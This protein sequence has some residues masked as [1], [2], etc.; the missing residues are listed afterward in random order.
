MSITGK[1]VGYDPGGNDKHGVAALIVDSGRPLQ[2]SFRTTRNAHAALHWFT[3]GGMPLAAGIDTLTALSTGDS[4]WRPADLW[5]RN[6][7][8]KVQN[9]VVNP[10][11]LQGS[12]ALNGL[13][14][15]LSLRAVCNSILIS[16]THPKVLCFCLSCH[17]YDYEKNQGAMN[18]HLAQW[19]G[20]PVNTANEHEWDAVISSFAV[21]KGMSGAWPMDLHQ[22][23]FR[24]DEAL[25]MPG[26]PS[27]YYWPSKD[28]GD[29][30]GIP[31]APG[32]ARSDGPA[33][34][35]CVTSMS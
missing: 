1:I 22:R 8:P 13:A 12:M 20:L 18:A 16:E 3:D 15:M 14:V 11:Y 4:G 21:L 35:A 17:R 7:Y 10:N 27:H 30:A 33:P 32:R 6:E 2:L 26:G 23:P 29:R 31:A 24:A 19:L 25:V 28:A 34:D 5:L 9:S